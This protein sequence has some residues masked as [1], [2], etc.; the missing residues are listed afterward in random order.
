M[1]HRRQGNTAVVRPLN[2]VVRPQM[3]F[4]V[5][6]VTSEE[7]A[8]LLRAITTNIEQ[9]LTANLAGDSFGVGIDQLTLVVVSVDNDPV[10]N[11]AW[12]KPYRK[13]GSYRHMVT[14]ERIRFL[15]LAAEVSPSDLVAL[16]D[17]QRHQFVAELLSSQFST[18]PKRLP[19]GFE[20]PGLATAVCSA[21]SGVASVGAVA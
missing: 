13:L 10:A 1:M 17:S 19:R 15:S 14:S 3:N 12:A 21:L 18:R 20:F 4:R 7:T 16:P 8:V 2:S 11:E 9:V 6:S 5:T